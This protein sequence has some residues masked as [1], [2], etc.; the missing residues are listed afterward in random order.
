[1]KYLEWK[2][3]D[4]SGGLNDKIED[5]LIAD[6]E[7]SDCQN[8]VATKIGS[9]TKR[10]GQARLNSTDLGGLIQGLHAYYYGANRR[11]VTIANGI[12]YYWDGLTFQQIALP[13]ADYPSGL[14]TTAPIYFETLVNYMVAFNGIN[15]PWKWDG[16]VASVLANAP[17]DGQF[18]VLYKEKLFTVPKSEPSTLKWSDSFQPESWPSVNYWDIAKGDG[19]VVTVLKPYLGELTVFKRYS[20]H[21]LR[22]TSIDDFRLDL[23]EPNVGAVGPRAVTFEGMYLYFVADDG[24]YVYNG[25][26]AE[27]LTRNKIHGLWA[28]VNQEYLHKAVAGR[29]NG[30][31][32]FALPEGSSTYNNLI[33]AYDPVTRAWWPWRGINTSCFQEYNDGT[34]LIFYSGS[35]VDGFILQQ[36]TGYSDAGVAITSYW[37]G[38]SFDMGAAERQKKMKKAFII[39]SPGANDVSVQLSFDYGAWTNLTIDKDEQLVRRYRRPNNNKWRYMKPKFNHST[40]DQSFEVRGFMMQYKVKQPK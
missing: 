1:M 3:K 33:L 2:I 5:H 18:C 13:G 6:N 36:D 31:I 21:S 9:L 28:A 14:D 26:K 10:K 20:I 39:D 34:Q 35:S 38:K 27:N 8:V 4:F 23:I 32:W 11:L 15:K 30:F 17:A 7:A 16:T 29:W 40:L 24:I 22:G 19:D 12:P 25:A 37:E